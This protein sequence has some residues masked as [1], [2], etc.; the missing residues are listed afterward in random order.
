MTFYEE[1]AAFIIQIIG[2][3][4]PD[5]PLPGIKSPLLG[6][7]AILTSLELVHLLL[8]LEDWCAERGITFDW[9]SDSAMSASR[10]SYRSVESLARHLDGLARRENSE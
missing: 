3:E 9:T 10:G 6:P 5:K 4:Q 1:A 8:L 7:G 2:E